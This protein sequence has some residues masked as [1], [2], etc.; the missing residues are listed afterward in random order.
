M[1]GETHSE[2]KETAVAYRT[3]I[4][5][6]ALHD[7]HHPVYLV[8]EKLEPYLQVIVERFH[9]ERIILFGSHAYGQPDRDSDFDLLIIRRGIPSE[10][11]S[12]LEIAQAFWDVPGPRPSFTILSKTPERIAERLAVK[13]PFYEE[14]VGRGLEV[15]A[16]S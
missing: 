11:A 9:P 14:I 13:S 1:A 15:Y 4:E 3:A 6:P 5:F 7:P 10:K 12:N 16:A 2:L 8:A